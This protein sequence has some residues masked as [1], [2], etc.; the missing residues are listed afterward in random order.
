[1]SR[2]VNVLV[3]G[4]KGYQDF[5]PL[6]KFKDDYVKSTNVARFRVLHV[7]VYFVL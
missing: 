4:K 7:R 1:M 6:D 2:R 3:A 5:L